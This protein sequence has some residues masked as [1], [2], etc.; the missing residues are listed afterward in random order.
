MTRHLRMK[1]LPIILFIFY[2]THTSVAQE[3]YLTI[4]GKITNREN[5]EPVAYASISVSGK[6]IGTSSNTEGNFIFKIPESY[7]NGSLKI[8][9][10]GYQSFTRM[11]TDVTGKPV[12]ISLAPATVELQEIQVQAK[13]K[14]GLDI[15]KE[16]IA[17]IPLNYDTAATQM[18]AFYREETRLDTHEV[19]F[20][21]SVLEATKPSLGSKERNDQIKTV[22]ERRRKPDNAITKDIRFHIWLQLNGGAKNAL[23]SGN[24]IKFYQKPHRFSFLNERNFKH[25][26]FK[27]NSII[28]DGERSAYVIEVLPEK[29]TSKALV[30]GK[31]YVDVESLAFTQWEFELTQK[32]LD[33]ENKHNALLKKI[34]SAIIKAN[35]K[36][37]GAKEVLHFEKY[38]DKWYLKDVQRHFEALVN[39][40]IRNIENSL[41]KTDLLV[42]VTDITKVNGQLSGGEKIYTL[43]DSLNSQI[44]LEG[45]DAF[46]GNLNIIQ[47][48]ATDTLGEFKETAYST[49]KEEITRSI[50]NKGSNRENGFTRADTLQGKLTPLRT[51]YD[52]SFYHVDVKVDIDNKF[53]SGNNKIRFQVVTPFQEMQV[54]LFANM[55]IEKILF[56]NK[57]LSYTRDFNAVFI[58]FPQEM[59]QGTEQEII[60]Y[61][62]GNPK[63][64]NWSIPMDGGF[65]WDKDKEGNPWVQVV[66]QGSGASL[67]WPNKDHLSDEPDSMKIS[68]TVP[69]HL[70]EISN[71]RLLKTTKLPGNQTKYDW[72]VSYPI[73]NYNVTLN[74]GNYTHLQDKFITNDTLT[75]D[76]YA[77][78][79]NLEKAKMMFAGIKPMLACM[80]KYYGKY[81]FTRDGFTL[82]ESLYPMEHQSAVSFGKIPEGDLADSINLPMTLV[83]HEVSHEW[84]GNNVSCKDMADMWIHEAF[85]TY[86]E[87][88]QMKASFGEEGELG[89]MESLQQNAVN[90]EPVV[91]I[92][93]VNHIHYN[94][95]DMY[96]KGALVLNTFRHVLNNDSLW[97][98][99]LYGIQQDFR[100]Q[101]VTT[102]DI[103]KYVNEKTKTDYTYFFDQYLK[104]PSLPKLMVKLT[105]KDNSL[106]VNFKWNADVQDFNMPIKV[107]KSKNKFDF[108]RPTTIWQTLILPNMDPD[109]FEVDESRFYIEAEIEE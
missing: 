86:T 13:G 49:Q 28:S 18:M 45:K 31:I 66:C 29:K 24:M 5:G 3:K 100:Y 50:P 60:I 76:Y 46:W 23:Q 83:W 85:A 32:G 108:I 36:F 65:L 42:A 68:V 17:A 44:Q 37:S 7:K 48:T 103:V 87:G 38:R 106:V 78:P 9:C 98:S 12:I 34:G 107:T 67:W 57:E 51:C 97:Y 27:L 104:Y 72:Q 93:D 92:Y 102:D 74:I 61:Y 54:D 77:M 64:P 43:Q 55:R 88:L 26:N 41:W 91:G 20:V 25:Y 69:S 63:V 99:I 40:K 33:W 10:I 8:S 90:Q 47:P 73:N 96:S 56:Q 81:P 105:E 15:I 70:K 2:I 84:W 6:S 89:Y 22:K 80:E 14:T 94:I 21:E 58:R 101:T 4:S 95:E 59:K 1:V 71:G 62:S 82:M 109:D 30:Q 52:V 53:I 39:S 19:T 75:L 16:A 35:L 79:Y 11:I